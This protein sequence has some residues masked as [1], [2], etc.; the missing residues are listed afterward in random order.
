M[1]SNIEVNMKKVNSSV[2]K[3][4]FN[5]IVI[6]ALASSSA[7]IAETTNSSSNLFEMQ[8]LESGYM[9]FTGEGKCGGE[10]SCGAAKREKEGKCGA[11]AKHEAKCG[12]MK[13]KEGKCGAEKKGME[14]SCGASKS[15]EHS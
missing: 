9:Q 13:S 5:A 14:G 3:L 2:N 1:G 11:K 4:A 10:A 8:S 15:K 6:G 12:E 7:V